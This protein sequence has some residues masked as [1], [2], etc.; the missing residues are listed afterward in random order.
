M[1]NP[2]DSYS[3]ELGYRPYHHT[4]AAPDTLCAVFFFHYLS[5]QK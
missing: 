3:V 4:K 5:F 2:G 1:I